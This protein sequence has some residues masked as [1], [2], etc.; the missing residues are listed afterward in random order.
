MLVGRLVGLV[1]TERVWLI[2]NKAVCLP[3]M[4]SGWLMAL[5]NCG[6]V[7]LCI[8]MLH[9]V[10]SCYSSRKTSCR[11]LPLLQYVLFIRL[12][13]RLMT[14]N[15]QQNRI[16]SHSFPGLR[17]LFLDLVVVLLWELSAGVCGSGW[18]E[19]ATFISIFFFVY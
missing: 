14:K 8:F 2:G 10:C 1:S 11:S 3:W 9:F 18:M 16:R 13:L 4:C 5:C 15:C 6:H 12:C 7:I 17:C 19:M